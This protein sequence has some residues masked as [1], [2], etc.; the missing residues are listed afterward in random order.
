MSIAL[1]ARVVLADC[2]LQHLLHLRLHRSVLRSEFMRLLGRLSESLPGRKDRTVFQINNINQIL[3]ILK[4]VWDLVL[5]RAIQK[6]FPPAS[7]P[8]H[9]SSMVAVSTASASVCGCWHVPYPSRHCVWTKKLIPWCLYALVHAM[10]HSVPPID[11]RAGVHR[12][13]VP[14]C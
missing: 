4:E 14:R 9:L 13:L 2:C 11:P 8:A 3:V 1:L 10:L 5:A 7:A 6:M 12:V